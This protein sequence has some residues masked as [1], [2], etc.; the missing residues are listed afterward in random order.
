MNASGGSGIRD[1]LR[2]VEPPLR[3]ALR[4]PCRLPQGGTLIVAVSGGADSTALLVALASLAR[5]FGLL[6]HAA[7]LDHGLRG[8]ESTADARAVRVL[9]ERLHVPLVD[10]R[11]D[12][13]ARLRRR[14]LS[15]EAGL[16]TLRRE[17]LESVARRV[18]AAAIATAHTA[19]D[20]LE[21][22]LMR[23]TRGSGLTGAAG[24][25]PRRG[26][27]IKPLLHVTRAEIESDLRRH[28]I[29][30]R[31]D[32]SNATH[33]HLRNRIRHIAVPA[34]LDAL[35]VAAGDPASRRATLARRASARA[36]ELADA[37][38]ALE[39]L[40]ARALVRAAAAGPAPGRPPE[41][42]L[43]APSR[44][45]ANVSVRERSH[46]RP[47]AYDLATLSALPA[48]VQRL[49]LRRAWRQGGERSSP[50]L[51]SRHLRPMLAALA[52]A[53]GRGARGTSLVTLPA[54]WKAV[55]GQGRLRFAPP[56]V[57]SSRDSRAN[58]RAGASD[59]RLPGVR[60]RARTGPAATRPARRRTP[61]PTSH[62][63]SPA[64]PAGSQE[65]S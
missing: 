22:L 57:A 27:W 63:H 25:R 9:C 55:L 58:R 5:E 11:W 21:T 4:G 44:R 35:G 18:S 8:A 24:M 16:R 3:R 31:E 50:G 43:V 32:A 40:A 14:G 41:K 51:T 62:A 19:D 30:W 65:R 49:A 10:A 20:Q 52:D 2:R 37:G 34:L 64:R 59:V 26:V 29:P 46:S 13:R 17:W 48:A 45:A 61:S 1:R 39:R 54:G 12:C 36:A 28:G 33:A 56:A 23:L 60:R 38:R 6:L 7:H 53:R 42:R 47:A 15:G